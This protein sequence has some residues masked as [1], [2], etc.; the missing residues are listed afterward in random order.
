[1]GDGQPF[2]VIDTDFCLVG[3]V[4][5][6]LVGLLLSSRTVWSRERCAVRWWGYPKV[7]SKASTPGETVKVSS[8]VCNTL[9]ENSV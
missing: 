7:K 1:M 4:A 9:P 6:D 2:A 3:H 8:P 5:F